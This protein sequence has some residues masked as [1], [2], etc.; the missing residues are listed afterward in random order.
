MT[1]LPYKE[2]PLNNLDSIPITVKF[3]QLDNPTTTND[4]QTL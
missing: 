1:V 3:F 2:S 4:R